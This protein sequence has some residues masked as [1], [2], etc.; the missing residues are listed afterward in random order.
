[1]TAAF[2]IH[3]CGHHRHHRRRVGRRSRSRP[4]RAAGGGRQPRF[5]ED[6]DAPRQAAAG[7]P[8]GRCG[9]ARAARQSGIGLRHRHPVPAPADRA[10]FGRRRSAAPPPVR[11][12]RAPACR[13]R[14]AGGLYSGTAY[15]RRPRRISGAGFGH[16]RRAGRVGRADRP[17]DR[18][19][20]SRRRATLPNI[21]GSLDELALCSYTFCV[22][23][24]R[25]TTC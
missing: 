6:R 14:R 19:A 10:P 2:A 22:R 3:R 1:M 12:A 5:L 23:S 13:Q 7:G 4:P 21:C 20:R 16:A 18:R 15:S 8:A 24:R 17:P 25:R 9:G 11:A